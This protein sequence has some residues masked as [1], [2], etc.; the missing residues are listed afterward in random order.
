MP[1]NTDT[2]QS[3]SPEDFA[4]EVASAPTGIVR[5]YLAFLRHGRRWWLAPILLILLLVSVLVIA[6]GTAAAPFIY[7]LF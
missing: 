4:R 6:S 3:P 7:A 1:D 5:E 2:T